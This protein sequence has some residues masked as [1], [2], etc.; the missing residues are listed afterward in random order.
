MFAETYLDDEIY[1]DDSSGHHPLDN[2]D[3]MMSG[4]DQDLSLIHI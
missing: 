4:G 1:D 3:I 2:D